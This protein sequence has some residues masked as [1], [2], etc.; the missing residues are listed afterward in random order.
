M[1]CSCE[2]TSSNIIDDTFSCRESQGEFRNTVVYRAMITLQVPTSI[3]DAD[4]IVVVLSEWVESE[5]SVRVNRVTLD[6][7]S[8]CPTMLESFNSND[9]EMPSDGTNP[10]SSSSSS[11]S[12]GIIVGAAVAAL[13]VTLLLIIAVVI[14]VMYRRHKSVYRYK[15]NTAVR[16]VEMVWV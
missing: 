1:R 3:T 10:S 4:N 6:I 12:V 13:V 16:G 8:G 7:D 15:L 9:C 11:L 2:F 14:I 5:P